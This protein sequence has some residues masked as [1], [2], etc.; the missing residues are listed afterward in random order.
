MDI[1]LDTHI[2]IWAFDD[3]PKLSAR[4]R[5]LILDEDNRIFV[6]DIS[7]WEIALK[8]TAHPDKIPY[9]SR[10]FIDLCNDSGFIGLPLTLS[11]IT[12]SEELDTTDAEGVHKDPFDRILIAQ[13]KT[14][15]MLFLTH[16]RNLALYHEPLAS[17]V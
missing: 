11:A 15:K 5:E 7:A 4:A 2:A 6:S 9:G 10:R 13:A 12:A 1:L 8:H 16:N 17:L 3:S 14:A